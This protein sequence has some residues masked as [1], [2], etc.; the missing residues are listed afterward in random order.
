ILLFQVKSSLVFLSLAAGSL[1]TDFV[2]DGALEFMQYFIRDFSDSALTIV[3][4]V[5]LGLPALIT[6]LLLR[7]SAGGTKFVTNIFPALLT[8]LMAV[9]LTV[10]LL[11][12]GL[13]HNVIASDA[14][15]QLLQ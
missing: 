7:K 14:Y 13:R 6:M 3:Q 11:T 4:L 2:A 12:P 10:P 5:L 9:Y 8:G 15:S 1:L